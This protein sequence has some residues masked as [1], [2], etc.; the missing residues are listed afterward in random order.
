VAR[1]SDEQ[2]SRFVEEDK[3]LQEGWDSKI[4]LRVSRG[5]RSWDFSVDGCDGSQFGII[6]RQNKFDEDNFS[7]ILGLFPQG[8]K[9]LFHLRRYDGKDHAHTN[10]IEN[11]ALNYVYHIHFATERYQDKGKDEDAFAVTSD[12]YFDLNSA[13]SCLLQDCNFTL[14]VIQQLSVFGWLT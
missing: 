9:K 7:V 11:E 5:S 8:S 4:Q 14:P 13:F 1:Y 10:S 2:I 6:L 12:R 3:Y